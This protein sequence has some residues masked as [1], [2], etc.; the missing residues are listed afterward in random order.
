MSG[1]NLDYF[2]HPS[3]LSCAI[4][5]FVLMIAGQVLIFGLAPHYEYTACLHQQM[6]GCNEV[7]Y[8]QLIVLGIALILVGL[9]FV[10]KA[11]WQKPIQA[12][13]KMIAQNTQKTD[14]NT[15]HDKQFHA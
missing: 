13:R 10:L 6:E 11:I 12:I 2:D 9:Y 14:S 4:A 8:Y 15:E 3:A 1:R 7:T 5:S